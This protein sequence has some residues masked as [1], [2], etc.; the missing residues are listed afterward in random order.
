[1]TGVL[2]CRGVRGAT[3]AEANT[4]EAILA[5]TRDLLEMVISING[6][7]EEAVASVF[8]T[9]TPDLNAAYPAGAARAIGW[10]QTAL[11]GAQEID[12]PTGIPRCIRIL[13]HWNT[14]KGIDELQHVYMRGAERLR[15]DLY[16]KNKVVLSE[17]QQP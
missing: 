5:A 13:I 9:T 3:T 16:P 8:F 1:M 10:T 17:E 2:M 6:I 14:T 11:I 12:L 4:A 15:P 7:Q